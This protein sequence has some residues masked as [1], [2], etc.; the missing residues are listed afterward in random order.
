MYKNNSRDSSEFKGCSQLQLSCS[1]TGN[2]HAIGYYSY[3]NRCASAR[4]VKGTSFTKL[5]G[6]SLHFLRH[7]LR[8]KSNYHALENHNNYGTEN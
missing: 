6:H 4:Y 7:N 3:T 5:K 1:L 2:R 8:G